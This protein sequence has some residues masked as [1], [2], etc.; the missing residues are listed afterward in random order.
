MVEGSEEGGGRTKLIFSIHFELL[1]SGFISQE[2]IFANF[3][4]LSQFAKI[5]FANIAQ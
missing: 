1:Y 3:A 2:K 5:L 4:D